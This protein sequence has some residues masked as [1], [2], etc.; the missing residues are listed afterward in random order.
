MRAGNNG[1]EHRRQRKLKEGFQSAHFQCIFNICH[2]RREFDLAH[3]LCAPFLF[4]QT[5][6]SSRGERLM[7]GLT[8]LAR[9]SPFSKE[10][11]RQSIVALQS[12]D[13]ITSRAKKDFRKSCDQVTESS[14]IVACISLAESLIRQIRAQPVEL[15]HEYLWWALN[16]SARVADKSLI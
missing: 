15:L 13:Y 5:V 8:Q 9:E 10:R 6:K 4:L 7:E 11:R 16:P 1:W 2:V 12:A 3:Y 14:E